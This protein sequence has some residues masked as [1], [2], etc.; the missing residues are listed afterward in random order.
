MNAS[1]FQHVYD[2]VRQ[3]PAGEVAS[4]SQIAAL[5]EQ[6]HNAR[7]VGWAM[8]KA[9]DDVPAHRVLRKDGSTAPAF[10]D[11]RSKLEAEG[12]AFDAAGRVVLTAH[13]WR[14]L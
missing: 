13:Q 4:Y 1:F 12:V 6:P 9:P 14:G 11:Q 3:I 5:L 10:V 8:Q 7:V 2:I